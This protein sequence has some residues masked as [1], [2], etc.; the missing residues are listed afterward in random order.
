MLHT[1]FLS[2]LWQKLNI[3]LVPSVTNITLTNIDQ[4][5]RR[6]YDAIYRRFV[7]MIYG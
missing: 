7:T 4:D 2:F 6:I 3:G 5:L 1:T